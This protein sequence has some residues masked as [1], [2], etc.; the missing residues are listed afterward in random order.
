MTSNIK[1]EVGEEVCIVSCG[2]NS[3]RIKEDDGYVRRR[4]GVITKVGRKFFFVTPEGSN[5]ELKFYIEG[6]KED[7][8][9]YCADNYLYKTFEDYKEEVDNQRATDKLKV[10]YFGTFTDTKL[11]VDQCERIIKI[12]EEK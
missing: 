10:D 4:S 11:T 1:I 5:W 3:G 12:I 2:A 6:M 9:G 7:T 8:G